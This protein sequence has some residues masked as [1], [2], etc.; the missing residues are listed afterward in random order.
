MIVPDYVG[1][2]NDGVQGYLDNVEQGRTVLDA[3]RALDALLAHGPFARILVVGYSQGGGAALSAQALEKSWGTSGK[4]VGVVAFAPEWPIDMK[5][6]GYANL[7]ANPNQLTVTTGL[8][9]SSIAVL[10]A[11]AYFANR[12]GAGNAT[13]GF[14]LGQ[15]AGFQNAIESLCLV[16]LGGYLQGTALKL[17]DLVDDELRTGLLSCV[18]TNGATCSGAAKGYWS[19][20]QSNVL[21]SDPGGAPVVIVQGLL[22]QIL[23]A[24]EEAACI[25]AKMIADGRPPEVCVDG[26]ATHQSIVDA[27]G[28][29]GRAWGLAALGGKPHPV[30]GNTK[31]PACARP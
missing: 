23:P 7:L 5:S 19:F 27:Q 15:R 11:Y 28:A 22:D 20:L 4:L 18:Q 29:F 25:Q 9:K 6:F 31:L 30:C 1:L 8:S 21:A 14:P 24:G 26:T 16:P 17:G 2:G 3:G 12:V 13:D 10:R